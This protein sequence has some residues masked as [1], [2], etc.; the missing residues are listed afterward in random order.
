MPLSN[1]S[2]FG[3]KALSEAINILPNSTS[4]IRSLKLFTQKPLTTTSVTIEDR[5]GK[6]LLV[7][8]VPRGSDGQPVSSKPRHVY[9]FNMTHL[10]K[11]DVVHA[12][13]VQNVRAFGSQNKTETVAEL[14]ADKL[15]DMK[16]DLEYTREHLMLGALQGKILDA[17]GSVI[18]DLYKQFGL[19][20]KSHNIELSKDS[21]I[22]GKAM[23]TVKI[24]LRNQLK[25][26]SCTGWIVLCG[27][28]FYQELIYHKSVEQRYQ[29]RQNDPFIDKQIYEKFVHQ[30][31][32]YILYDHVFP[33]GSKIGENEA[34][35]I[36]KGT[37]KVFFEYFAPAN[38]SQ[39]VN[40]KALP[41]YASRERMKHDKGWD[42][43]AQSN[44]LPLVTRPDL[45]QTLKMT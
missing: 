17:D 15:L 11:H 31:V 30:G 43:E 33:K 35:I 21:T 5:E 45:V 3:V 20:R 7:P 27:T 34:I 16:N 41:Y 44:P 36:P 13:D 1:E 12:D 24:A 10:P 4:I 8:N 2:V 40:T 25:G 14:V 26:E 32:D 39:T 28:K 29:Q 23:D 38:K 9:N 19:T 42:L 18:T 37:R 6:L 22:V